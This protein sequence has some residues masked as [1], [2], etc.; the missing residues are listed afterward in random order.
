MRPRDL[1]YRRLSL[2]PTV[3]DAGRKKPVLVANHRIDILY[4]Q[5]RDKRS[6]LMQGDCGCQL[7]DVTHKDDGDVS[8]ICTA[9]G[10]PFSQV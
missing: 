5:D 6:D 9:R 8:R 1:H 7:T 2:P 4:L 3:E 10:L